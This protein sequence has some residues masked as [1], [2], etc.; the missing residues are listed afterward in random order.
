MALTADDIQQINL[1]VNN[2]IEASS[3]PAKRQRP[4]ATLVYEGNGSYYDPSTQAQW[5]K[6]PSGTLIPIT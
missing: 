2:A 3:L 6:G 1:I 5:V 4:P